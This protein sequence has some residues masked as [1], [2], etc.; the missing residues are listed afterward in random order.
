MRTRI[1]I[2]LVLA[3]G[4]ITAA[5]IPAGAQISDTGNAA[6]VQYPDVPTARTAEETPAED[7]GLPVTGYVALP[8]L[9]T[10]ALLLATGAVMHVR[11]RKE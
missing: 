5:P 11:T 8:L 2:G 9:L 7:N 4:L 10:G 6:E 1:A 3:V